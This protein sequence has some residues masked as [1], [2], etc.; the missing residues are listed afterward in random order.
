[1]NTQSSR[2][3]DFVC[4]VVYDNN[5]HGVLERLYRCH[6]GTSVIVGRVVVFSLPTRPD[7]V[8]LPHKYTRDGNSLSPFYLQ[9]ENCDRGITYSIDIGSHNDIVAAGHDT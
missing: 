4:N 3:T 6:C 9:V 5:G 2:S 7:P 1:M 8:R